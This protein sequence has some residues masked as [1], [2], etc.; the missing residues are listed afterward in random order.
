ME[1]GFFLYSLNFNLFLKFVHCD[2]VE[3]NN[4]PS[5]VKIF[6]I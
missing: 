6:V 5:F 1:P 3:I 2:Y 4:S